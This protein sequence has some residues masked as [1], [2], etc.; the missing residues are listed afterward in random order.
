MGAITALYSDYG[1][2]AEEVYGLSGIVAQSQRGWVS[3]D[4]CCPRTASS[5]VARGRAARKGRSN[6][7]CDAIGV[8]DANL[9]CFG[10]EID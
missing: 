8:T 3:C 1:T 2:R 9:A 7:Y 5:S 6:V 10:F 4:S